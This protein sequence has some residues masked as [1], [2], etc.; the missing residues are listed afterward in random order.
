V[1]SASNIT[2]GARITAAGIQGTAPQ[3]TIKGADQSVTSSITMIN[4]NALF[5]DLIADATYYFECCI[6]YQG[7]TQGSSDFQ[8]QWTVPS[9]TTMIWADENIT[10]GGAASVGTCWTQAANPTAG[11]NGSGN[12]CSL[13]MKGTISTSS[14]AGVLQLQWAQNTS[15][16]TATT[17]KAGSVLTLWQVSP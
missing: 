2:A 7:G 15:S 13:V 8:Y 14:T 11:A 16:G 17:V 10:T 1:T 9:G 6:F 3:A 5:T 4:D 12:K